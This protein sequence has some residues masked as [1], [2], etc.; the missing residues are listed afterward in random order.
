[1]PRVKVVAQR[2]YARVDIASYYDIS[3]QVQSHGMD[4]DKLA[5]AAASGATIPYIYAVLPCASLSDSCATEDESFRMVANQPAKIG[6]LRIE[7][8]RDEE[9]HRYVRA[10]KLFAEDT[11]RYSASLPVL[12]DVRLISMSPQAFTLAGFERIEGAEYA[13]SWLVWTACSG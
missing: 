1:M 12:L 6:D 8:C 4:R 11:T 13:Q 2:E 9:L 7:E 5:S 10:A 3:Q